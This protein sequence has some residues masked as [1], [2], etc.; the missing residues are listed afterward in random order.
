MKVWPKP[1]ILNFLLFALCAIIEGKAYAKSS[2]LLTKAPVSADQ[3]TGEAT[4]ELK[5]EMEI[6]AIPTPP[7]KSPRSFHYS[8]EEPL[9]KSKRYYSNFDLTSIFDY[10]ALKGTSL[11]NGTHG[12]LITGLNVGLKVERV[13][14]WISGEQ[15][16]FFV[17][18]KNLTF[19]DDSGGIKIYNKNV[20]LYSF[21]GSIK[22]Q[23]RSRFA[24]IATLEIVQTLY[25]EGSPNGDGLT[26]ITLPI[27]RIHP[28]LEFRVL[29]VG[30]LTLLGQA[31]ASLYAPSKYDQ[32]FVRTGY[33]YDLG[34]KIADTRE[35]KN[36]VHCK[37]LY[38]VRMQSTS[39]LALSELSAG[40]ECGLSFGGTP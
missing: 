1:I 6:M 10:V 30:S 31:N 33:G 38:G 14:H 18:G 29:K 34:L 21:G 13:Q 22:K 3:A 15:S 27:L 12:S 25:Y 11:S 40:L 23:T 24:L 32:Y 35:N 7:T 2:A 20:N 9:T 8:W 26:I 16:S 5:P 19:L 36:S 37:V 39:L 28:G 17:T 4:N